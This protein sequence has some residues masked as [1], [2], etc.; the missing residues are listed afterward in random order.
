MCE[1]VGFVPTVYAGR[2]VRC[3]NA[4]CLVPVFSVPM[5]EVVEEITDQ[6]P[7]FAKYGLFIG[8][9]VLI[10]G[11][12]LIAFFVFKNDQ[13]LPV[14]PVSP[15]TGITNSKP[16]DTSDTKPVPLPANPDD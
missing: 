6:K 4:D 5:P 12:G 1:A 7:F 16:E 9:A 3:H 10:V 11:T 8:L 15:G 13:K 2:E 14:N